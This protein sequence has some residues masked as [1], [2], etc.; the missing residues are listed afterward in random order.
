MATD[1]P[2]WAER[3]GRLVDLLIDGLRYGAPTPAY[4]RPTLLGARSVGRAARRPAQ[5]VHR[6]RHRDPG[7]RSGAGTGSP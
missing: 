4:R 1:S 6:L 7:R 3:T 2:G 5:A